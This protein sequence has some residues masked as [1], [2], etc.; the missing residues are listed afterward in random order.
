VFY[1]EASAPGGSMTDLRQIQ[2]KELSFNNLIDVDA[3]VTAATAWHDEDQVACVIIKHT[4]PCGIALADSPSDAWARALAC[5]PVSAFG[6]VVAFNRTVTE[7]VAGA[8]AGTFIEIVV[9]PDFEPGALVHFR[10]RKN[11]RVLCVSTVPAEDDELDFKRV[12]GGFLVQQRMS[13][14]FPEAEWSVVTDRSPSDAEWAD[15]RFAWRAA[16][17]V[18]SNAI[19]LAK[20]AMTVGI[21]AGQMSRVDASRLA[22]MKAHDQGMDLKGA[23]LASDA[24]F[25]FRDGVDAAASSGVVAMI[26]PGG[27]IR[28]EEVAAAAN[29][30]GIAMVFTRRRLF[31]H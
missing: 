15:L 29:E 27:S 1:G 16:A 18:K 5:D 14:R 22:V 31:R 12:R 21:G 30:H 3:G 11:L 9:A 10:G 4:T 2:G 19:V 8:M 7:E 25:P 13:M 20:G 17:S 24:F 6:S 23:V 28:D 26:Q